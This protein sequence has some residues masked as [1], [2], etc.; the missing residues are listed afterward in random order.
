MTDSE[1]FRAGLAESSE[2]TASQ[3][4][5]LMECQHNEKLLA[6]SVVSIASRLS[7]IIVETQNN[8]IEESGGPIEQRLGKQI[9]GPLRYLGE[10]TLPAIARQFD[11]VRRQIDR[12]EERDAALEQAIV[13]E[14]RAIATMKEILGFMMK[15]EG[16]QEAVNLLHQVQQEQRSVSDL[17]DREKRER[18]ERLLDKTKK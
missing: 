6:P 16:F 8:R 4:K 10:E 9:I 14:R 5:L 13:T 12:T 17:T 15:S 3:R 2:L 1:A 7:S 18:V 11:V